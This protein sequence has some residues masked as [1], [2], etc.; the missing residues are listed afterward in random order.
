[1]ARVKT[2]EPEGPADARSNAC[3]R[4]NGAILALYNRPQPQEAKHALPTADR[5]RRAPPRRVSIRTRLIALAFAIVLP[6]V[7]GALWGLNVLYQQQKRAA[8][9]NLEEI[10][11][12]I[13]A[14]VDRELARME[15]TLTTLA[16]SPTIQ[17]GDLKAFY[18][19][20][21]AAAPGAERTVVLMDLNGQQLVNTRLAFGE[22]LPRS[23][24][25]AELRTKARPDQSLVSDLYFAPV[26]KH[27]S[28][29]LQVPVMQ[30]GKVI[31]Y[32][33][34]GSFAA[35][36]QKAI[37][38][39]RLP[40][41]WNASVVDRKGMIVARRLKPEEF[42]SKQVTPDLLEQMRTQTEGVFETTRLDGVRTFTA[43]TPVSATGWTFVLSMPKSEVEAAIVSALNLTV[44]ITAILLVLA[45]LAATYVGMTISRPIRHLVS[46]AAAVGRGEQIRAPHHGL[47]ETRLVAMELQHASE[48]IKATNELMEQRI[49]EA[50]RESKRAQEA[51]LQ[52]QKLEALGKLTGGIAHDFNNL[53]QTI[54]AAIEVALRLTVVDTVKQAMHAGKRAVQRATKLTRQLTTFGRGTISAPTVI[55]L[56][57]HITEFRD[58][59]EGAL[60]GN[61][62]LKFDMAD[63]LWRVDVDPV[64]LEL[65]VLNA[66]LN[67]RDAMPNGGRLEI[68]GVNTTLNENDVPGV[69]AGEY[70][71]INIVDNGE[72][73]SPE[74]LKRVFEPFY[75]TKS[76]GKGSGLGLAQIYGF[77]RQS[78]G[79]AVLDSTVGQGTRLALYLPRSAREPDA[80][81]EDAAGAPDEAGTPCSVL[82]VEDDELVSEVVVPGLRSNGFNVVRA[83][84]ASSALDAMKEHRI[85]VVL[86]DIVMPGR[87]DGFY[88]ADEIRKKYPDV[89]IVLA[90]GYSDALTASSPFRVLLKPY[91]INEA[92]AALN[93]ERRRFKGGVRSARGDAGSSFPSP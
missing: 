28:F 41:R 24:A 61:I 64:Q 74:D 58:L 66:A 23:K 80:L 55:D 39:Q 27:Y 88:L 92:I 49:E 6:A 33:A 20:A 89:P 35:V 51:L 50:V 57:A 60:R 84:D 1:M 48:R 42:V 81:V 78:G 9:A 14:V 90:T 36:L 65:A 4:A 10:T 16:L 71:R 26:G 82:F 32:L 40:L 3:A 8:S 91:T 73:I 70:V 52:N 54:S 25:F 12:G 53:L 46:L 11:R 56:R 13:A 85:D 37:E 69:P 72:G 44:L 15:T 75:T 21:K 79:A 31:A 5:A 59:I 18:D 87:G 45:I 43:F 63:E 47:L 86:S 22:K 76:V 77:A 67:S 93:H 34:M 38:D 29:A 17:R 62:E 83:R 7:I 30:E 19:Y 68:S 2:P